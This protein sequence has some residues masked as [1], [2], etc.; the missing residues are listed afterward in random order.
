MS[1][2]DRRPRH[3]FP[4]SATLLT[5]GASVALTLFVVW[6]IVGFIAVP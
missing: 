1:S 4:P 2:F 3:R 6:A 5:I